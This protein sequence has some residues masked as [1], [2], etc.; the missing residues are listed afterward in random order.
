[1]KFSQTHQKIDVLK[2][3]TKLLYFSSTADVSKISV[4]FAPDNTGW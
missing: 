4:P 2:A 3:A 1:M